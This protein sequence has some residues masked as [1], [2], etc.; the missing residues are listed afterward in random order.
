MKVETKPVSA[1]KV[2]ITVTATS[3]ETK[4]EYKKVFNMYMKQGNIP[5]FRKGKAPNDIIQRTFGAEISKETE[6]RLCRSMYKQAVDEADI[7]LVSVLDLKDVKFA[8]ETGIEFVLVADVEPEFKLPKYK[9]I[10]VKPQEATVT[11][12]ELDDYMERMRS[13]FAKFEEAPENYAVEENDLVCIDFTATADGKPVKEVAPGTD[14]I[15]EGT[16]FWVQAD[17]KQFVP[18]VIKKIIGLKAGDEKKIS[19]KF[20]KTTPVEALRG[21]KAVYNVTLKSVRKRMVPSDKELCEQMK[22]ESLEDFRKDAKVK[23]L[24]TAEQ[25]EQKRRRQV[26]TEHLLKKASFDLPESEVADSVNNILDQMMRDAQMRGMKPEDLAS[27]REQILKNAT[28]S[29]TSQVRMKY[30]IRDIAAKEG[31]EASKEDVDAKLEEMSKEYNMEAKEI[32]KR[33]AENGNESVIAD[34]VVFDKT[35]EFLLAEAK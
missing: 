7:K 11:E 29:A 12:E 9:G 32:R 26:I 14:Q 17:E 21:L 6:S 33:L 5:G 25:N 18:Q 19:F 2:N 34:Q 22:T 8:P 4:G 10:A 28:E 15:S 1:C 24:E 30:I 23:M 20:L 3:E 35:I 13:A 31:I 27:Q 16:D